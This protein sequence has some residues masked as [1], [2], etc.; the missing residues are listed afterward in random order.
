MHNVSPRI[1]L[2]L[3]RVFD[4]I[5]RNGSLTQAAE[6]LHLTQPAVSHALGRLR[7]R[8]DDPLFRRQ[9]RGVVPT[10]RAH[11]LAPDVRQALALLEAGLRGVAEFRPE[12]AR[13][14][15]VVGLRDSTELGL[16]PSWMARVRAQAPGVTLE[17]VRF[18]RQS[19][20]RDLTRGA[21]DLVVDVPQPQQRD[22]MSELLSEDQLCVAMRRDHPLAAA[23]LDQGQ[24][25]GAAHVVVSSRR[26]GLSLEDAELQRRG[27]HRRIALRCQNYVAACA[28]VARSDLLL[29]LPSGALAQVRGMHDLHVTSVPITLPAVQLQ[30]YWHHAA[31]ED[32]GNRWLRATLMDAVREQRGAAPGEGVQ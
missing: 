26:S 23:P 11:A 16:L 19:A 21:L 17:C 15:F 12:E 29:T 13:R 31:H 18:S 24:W 28:V 2:N 14:R 5:Y 6:A 20:M 1:D 10:P 25:I 4:A 32:T 9:G 7:G 30:L 3:F 22:I 27:L 8:F